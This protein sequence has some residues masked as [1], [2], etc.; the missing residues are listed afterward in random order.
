MTSQQTRAL[1]FRYEGLKEAVGLFQNGPEPLESRFATGYSL[2]LNLLSLYTLE[3]V[4]HFLS[5]SFRNYQTSVSLEKR[6]KQIAE[7]KKKARMLVKETQ[8]FATSEEQ[9]ILA[10][11]NSLKVRLPFL[12]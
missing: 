1:L 12:C 5:K 8:R 3:D 11:Y 10:E 6:Q 4:R 7:L 2:V 9:E